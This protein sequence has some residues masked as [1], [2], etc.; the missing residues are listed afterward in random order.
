MTS[1]DKS[2]G[3]IDDKEVTLISDK[4]YKFLNF[5]NFTELNQKLK[6]LSKDKEKE[7]I[8][9][10]LIQIIGS[11]VKTKKKNKNKNLES[12]KYK[13]DG[14]DIQLFFK[15]R[16]DDE[17]FVFEPNLENMVV[18][19][20]NS[21]QSNNNIKTDGFINIYVAPS[22]SESESLSKA[23]S[24]NKP[25]DEDLEEEEEAKEEASA[26]VH[27][28]EQQQQDQDQETNGIK[29]KQAKEDKTFT[30]TFQNTENK[31]NEELK[32]EI[33]ETDLTLVNN[34]Q[35]NITPNNGTPDNGTPDNGTPGGRVIKSKSMTSN[36]KKRGPRKEKQEY[37]DIKF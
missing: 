37:I 30:E 20:T 25:E 19:S 35:T 32:E 16:D 11:Y 33:N 23:A 18:L 1:N 6:D 24:V 12:I 28:E 26:Q 27:E 34:E 17:G 36:K 9:K 14:N 21:V 4:K 7:S 22:E 10:E 3:H 8:E 13:I 31:N 5:N 15:Y 2:K 29:Q